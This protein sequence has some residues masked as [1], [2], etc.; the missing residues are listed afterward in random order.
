MMI[1]LN[2]SNQA[3]LA[4]LARI[5]NTTTKIDSKAQPNIFSG[6]PTEDKLDHFFN[7]ARYHRWTED[8]EYTIEDT[9][10]DKLDRFVNIARYH[11]WT[12]DQVY[13]IEER[14]LLDGITLTWF[15]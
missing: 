3:L 2:N 14:T 7:I 5:N 11:R 1:Q 4:M 13:T 8:Q 6:L 12:E 9:T 15:I 10:E